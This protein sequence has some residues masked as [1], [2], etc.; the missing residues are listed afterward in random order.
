M[1]VKL[2]L[3]VN[4]VGAKAGDEI[5]VEDKDTADYLVANGHARRASAAKKSAD[6]GSSSSS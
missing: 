4:T 1:S 2:I 5:E 3:R 6:S